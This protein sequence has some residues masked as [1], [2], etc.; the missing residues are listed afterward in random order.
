VFDGMDLISFSAEQAKR[1]QKMFSAVVLAALDDAIL[2]EK[3]HGTGV[4]AIAH[5][6]RSRDGRLILDSAG[7]E[8][9]DRTISRMQDFVRRGIRTTAA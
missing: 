9:N 6:A 8:C 2:E 1:S 3:K 7:I 4:A 5:W